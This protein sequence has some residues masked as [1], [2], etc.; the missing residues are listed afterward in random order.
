[1]N[2]QYFKVFQKRIAIFSRSSWLRVNQ[3]ELIAHEYAKNAK[4]RYP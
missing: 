2:S 4:G 3:K 1:M